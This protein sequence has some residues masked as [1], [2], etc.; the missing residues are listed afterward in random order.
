MI[1]RTAAAAA[2]LFA[3]ASP[4]L[5]QS[6]PFETKDDASKRQQSQ[7]YQGQQKNGQTLGGPSQPLGDGNAGKC[8]G[9]NCPKK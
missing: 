3:L 4:A 2:L 5:A 7:Q 6:K 9:S 1:V 8:T